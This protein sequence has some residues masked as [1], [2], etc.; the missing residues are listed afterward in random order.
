MAQKNKPQTVQTTVLSLGGSLIVPDSIDT[1]FLKEFR[2]LVLDYTEDGKD[3]SRRLVIVTGGGKTCRIYNEAAEKIAKIKNDDLDWLGIS[4]TKLNA[5]LIRCILS[6]YAYDKVATDPTVEIKTDKC[7]I[8]ASGYTSGYSSD[9]VAV[10]QAKNF[11]AKTVINMTNVDRVY[12]SDPRKNKN[13]KAF[14]KLSWKEFLS[15]IG[16]EWIP[17]KNVPFDPVASRLAMD[18]SI[19]TIILNGKDLGNL[20]K[21]L[22]GKSFAGTVIG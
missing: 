19:K 2:K 13:A 1:L 4:A 5:E 6:D 17:G 15:I 18:N 14:D 16:E 11:G 20:R 22:D 3:K 21:C 9:K 10:M 7:I 8:I 12:D